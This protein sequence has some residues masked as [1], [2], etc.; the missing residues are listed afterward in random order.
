M[1]EASMQI[2]AIKIP[3]LKHTLFSPNFQ[4]IVLKP[5]HRLLNVVQT[6]KGGPDY[7]FQEVQQIIEHDR[8]RNVLME[9]LSIRAEMCQVK[10]LADWTETFKVHD[11]LKPVQQFV[12]CL[13]IVTSAPYQNRF[14]STQPQPRKMV[15]RVHA[16]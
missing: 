4:H 10:A 5:L 1:R 9:A 11:I 3:L 13:C 16:A 6:I 14:T 7:N 12:Y 15:T 8:L 2:K